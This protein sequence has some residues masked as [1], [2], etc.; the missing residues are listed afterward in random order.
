MVANGRFKA[1]WPLEG[2][3]LD[4]FWKEKEKKKGKHHFHLLSLFTPQDFTETLFPLILEFFFT[5]V[6]DFYFVFFFSF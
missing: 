1:W 3:M 6:L 4:W 5:M 2:S